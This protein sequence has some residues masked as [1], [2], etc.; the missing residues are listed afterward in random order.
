[1]HTEYV[2]ILLVIIILGYSCHHSAEEVVVYVTVDQ[3]Y[4]EPVLR[5]FEKRTG[6]KV[7]A[8]FDTEETKS[9]GILNR[10]IAEKNNP[11]CDVFWSG[12]PMR[13]EVLRSR[14]ILSVYHP[15]NASDIPE[16]FKDKDG[17]WVGFSVRSRV[18][19]YNTELMTST[20]A[21]QSIFDLTRPEYKGKVAMAN[22][23]FGTTTFHI[24][25]LFE[26]I[27]EERAAAFLD[28]LKN[29][30]LV[31]LSSNG[32]VKKKVSQGIVACGLTDTD[33]VFAAVREGNPV[34]MI[35]LDQQG[36]GSLI[37]PN[38]VSLIAGSPHPENGKKLIEY[39]LEKDTESK[40]AYSCAQIPLRSGVDVPVHVPRIEDI[41]AMQINY[42]AA[43]QKLEAIQPFL[44]QW[45]ENW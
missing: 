32:D 2:Y 33:D 40:L 19:I 44:K 14:N 10:L 24:A 31:L 8:V 5:D 28:S 30:G 34:D 45:I 27:G 23:L 7:K 18:L 22:P 42:H 4:A 20:T 37:I 6:I 43:A 35:F 11:K 13:T 9:T 39:L 41:R 26:L 29:N 21:P 17:Y 15:Q 16:T 38:T 1:M 36:I 3:A 25:A 12:D